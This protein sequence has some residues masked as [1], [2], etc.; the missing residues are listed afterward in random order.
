MNVS[1]LNMQVSNLSR[2]F[3]A[4]MLFAIFAGTATA[5]EF[6]FHRDGILGTSFDLTVAARGSN[7]A[8]RVEQAA[9]GEI[10]RLARILS[11]YDKTSDVSRINGSLTPV[12]VAPE[13]FDVLG[14]CEA[15]GARS[16]GAY[17]GQLGELI[18]TWKL[19]EKAGTPPTA[20]LVQPVIAQLTQPGW[21]LDRAAGTVTR[22][23]G[24]ALNVDSFGKGYIISKAAAVAQTATEG[25]SG[26]MLNIGGD[27][28]AWGSRSATSAVP[29]RVAVMDPRNPYDNFRPLTRVAVS[30]LAVSTSAG[31][32]RSY[33]FGKTSYSH[34]LD[35]RT[36]FPATN[37]ASATVIAPASG[38]ANALATTLCVLRPDEGLQLVQ[39]TPGAE[40]LIV[41]R[42][43]KQWKS[44]GFAA[45][46]VARTATKP[47]ASKP[48]LWPA[49]YELAVEVTMKS[50]AGNA[51]RPYLVLWIE[52]EQGQPVRTVT[53]WGNK[54]KY[55]KDLPAW[56]RFAKDDA[57]NIGDV[58]R[59]TRNFGRYSI[60][61]DGR[62]DQGEPLPPGTYNITLEV[63]R[64]H[65]THA[66][67]SVKIECG[68]KPVNAVIQAGSEFEEAP[69]TYGPK[70]G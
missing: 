9:L 26:G 30:G 5:A 19:S 12:K 61:W 57:E 3:V 20:A 7:E 4:M 38:T 28:F 60:Q 6:R 53:L 34:I 1:P 48:S 69:V 65:G 47:G 40:C 32:A 68:D 14:A 56:W 25:V 31:Y 18:A 13:V 54:S 41:M 17:S 2:W 63:T 58:S 43:G 51:K 27:I 42:D 64:E 55:F 36:G 49:G 52:N 59:A 44:S 8:E 21:T 22:R 10:Q 50:P 66:K 70:G 67:R 35:P 29:W 46:E 15:W 16:K 11:S 37:A 23:D 45:L 39:E 62:D 24:V 33:R